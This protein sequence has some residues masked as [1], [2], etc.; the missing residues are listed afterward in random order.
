[1]DPAVYLSPRE[2]SLLESLLN[3][4]INRGTGNQVDNL[5]QALHR[6]V[7]MEGVDLIGGCEV[8]GSV[9]AVSL[10]RA[11]AAGVGLLAEAGRAEPIYAAAAAASDEE[12]VAAGW[13]RETCET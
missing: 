9:G 12:R 6:I 2:R 11:A 7:E 5:T 8:V 3:E 4:C 13:A 1:M 10:L